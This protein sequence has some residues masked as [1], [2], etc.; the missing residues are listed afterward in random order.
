[1]EFDQKP[2]N[3]LT[4]NLHLTPTGYYFSEGQNSF[5]SKEKL[6]EVLESNVGQHPPSFYTHMKHITHIHF[7]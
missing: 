6:P 2:Q 4:I 5:H 7:K 3:G 1:M